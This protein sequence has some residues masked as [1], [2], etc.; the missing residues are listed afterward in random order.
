MKVILLQD[1]AKIG[2]RGEVAEVPNG[3]AQNKLIPQGMA[4]PATAVNLKQVAALHAQASTAQA[5]SEASFKE[6][7]DKLKD[8]VI[9]L[10]QEA[11]EKGH[12]FQAV[13]VDDIVAAAAAQGITVPPQ[14]VVLAQ[15]IKDV[16]THEIEL[17]HGDA[18]TATLQLEV[19]AK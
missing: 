15:P 2:R 16:G 4:K 10:A 5:D 11:N 17:S 6:M 18:M 19:T 14:S 7:A 3:Y 9:A 13:K 1:V 8:T 12:L